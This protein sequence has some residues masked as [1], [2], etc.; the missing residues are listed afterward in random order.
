MRLTND[1]PRKCFRNFWV[2]NDIDLLK[3]C[4]AYMCD[5]QF[6]RQLRVVQK[7]LRWD[8]GNLLE[9]RPVSLRHPI[10]QLCPS[11]DQIIPRAHDPIRGL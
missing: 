11:E 7:Q 1:S 10:S 9:K 2:R 6:S 4:H 3:I 5:S 8:N